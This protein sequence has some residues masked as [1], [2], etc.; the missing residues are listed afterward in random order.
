MRAASENLTP[1]TLELGGKDPFIVFNSASLGQALDR[2]MRGAFINCGQ[3]CISAER[4]YVQEGKD[5]LPLSPID[6]FCY[7]FS[8]FFG[9]RY[10]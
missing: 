2:A 10:L 4:F 8:L 1:V 6:L 9:L 7:F 5:L 3:N